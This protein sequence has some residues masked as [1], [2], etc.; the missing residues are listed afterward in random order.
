M[1]KK[2]L[3]ALHFCKYNNSD[4]RNPRRIIE[5]LASIMCDN[6][7]GF[8]GKLGDQLQ[9][10]HSKETIS[11]AFRVLLN[12]PLH[13][14]EEQ[15]PM[16][17]VIDA[18]D[19]SEVGGKSEFLQLI[20]EEFPN[21]PQWIKILITSRPELLVQEEFHHLNPL[22]I[23]AHNK[24]NN[25]DLLNYIRNCL[26]PI[27]DDDNVLKNL[28]WKCN[29]SFLYAYYTQM[30]LRKKKKPLT[31]D[32]ISKLVPEGMCGFY[33]KQFEHLEKQLSSLSQS[34][35]NFKCFLEVLVAAEG[36]LPIHFLPEFLGLPNDTEYRVRKTIYEIMSL[37]LPVY[38]D[39]LIIY[40][41][42]LI[43]WLTSSG[44]KEHAFTVDYKTGHSFLWKACEKVFDCIVSSSAF[45]HFK[46][47]ALIKYALAYGVSHLIHTSNK[48]SYQ[49]SV[50]VKIV[51]ARTLI[52]PYRLHRMKEEWLEIVES[53]TSSLSK[54]LLCELNWHIRL[55]Q[56]VSHLDNSSFYLQSV[57]NR[58]HCSVESRSHAKS[59][60]ELGQY[61]WFEDLDT[62][63]LTKNVYM[64]VSLR[65]DVTCINVSTD[66]K[67][68]AVGYRNGWVSIFSLPDFTEVKT[69]NTIP[70][71][72]ICD[73]LST[74][75]PDKYLLLYDRYERH[76]PTNKSKELP[77]F[78][79]EYGALW[80]C[81]FSPSGK[82]LVTCDGSV[83]IKLWDVNNGILLAELQ[84]GGTVD[85]CSF[86]ESGMFIVATRE[87]DVAQCKD[88]IDVFTLWSV[89]TL[90]R[91]DRRHIGNTFKFLPDRIEELQLSSNGEFIDV[92]LLPE[93]FLF[94]RLLRHYFPFILPVTRYHWRDCVLHH[95]N[96]TID[97]SYL[98]TM[99]VQKKC[100]QKLPEGVAIY[101]IGCP[102]SYLRSTRVAPVI[103][104]GL[105]VV[106][107]FD[108]LN[109]FRVAEQPSIV[110]LMSR[111]ESYLIACCC[112]SPDGSFLVTCANGAP[113]SILIWDTKLCTVVDILR[114][115]GM[116]AG[117]CWWSGNLLWIYMDDG[118]LVKIPI[119]NGRP[120]KQRAKRVEI[121]WEPVKLLTFSDVLIFLNKENSVNVARV[122]NGELQYV[123]KLP[124][125][126]SI[127]CAA[128]SP[129][130]S[131]VLTAG[132]KVFN[133]W[134]VDPAACPLHWKTSSSEQLSNFPFMND[135]K[136]QLLTI[137]DFCCK[138]CI[139]NDGST[140]VLAL[141]FTEKESQYSFIPRCYIICVNLKSNA[142]RFV[143]S[144]AH[145]ARLGVL[146][147]GN[148]YCVALDML[149]GSLVAAKLTTGEVVAKWKK[150]REFDLKSTIVAHSKNG[151]VAVISTQRASVQLL[152]IVVP[153]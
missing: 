144:S 131:V 67:F 128:V 106:P 18:L 79:G 42:S 105:Y 49:W 127:M 43:D 55:F 76:S 69:F 30:E 32:N 7:E 17:L 75:S 95:T 138:C 68:V 34:E 4:C 126:N 89:L 2:Q 109:I 101:F 27:C 47:D 137:T 148:S 135:S 143:I 23:D 58:M 96:G 14:L 44:Y 103:V 94:M 45:P 37:I 91:V 102:C 20:A 97:F 107:I 3:A 141:S 140:G 124:D 24:N 87:R 81:A 139:T 82:R 152:K 80:S 112:F 99:I 28:A 153:D 26:S 73:N 22:H 54:K 108:K 133:V 150:L 92:F 83:T 66:E 41:R 13:A 123:E 149:G 51:H 151:H 129:C 63:E 36:P 61:F 142:T 90:K 5:S 11:D 86:S 113:L 114:F 98:E 77:V 100:C 147:V 53:S 72:N 84:A 85:C 70:E 64:A 25:D 38:D 57:A 62:A 88:Q 132:V 119:I 71:S 145:I 6:V 136:G 122:V 21:L 59:W 56:N 31:H 40:H 117:G 29:G 9:R 78:G 1:K 146:Y 93:A 120:I 33:K 48:S 50:D 118:G 134:K 121:N 35:I 46:P 116:C 74:F 110:S 15:K 19:E 60:L 39:C 12:D 16:L 115:P 52:H 125:D 130:S 65:S 111:P 10:N 8:K 104:Q